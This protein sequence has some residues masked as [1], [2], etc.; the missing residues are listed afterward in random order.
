MERRNCDLIIA[1]ESL[2][3][4]LKDMSISNNK[5]LHFSNLLEMKNT[6]FVAMFRR[7]ITLYIHALR[8]NS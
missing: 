1:M 4:F 3:N 8:N 2:H 5:L 6:I 7:N